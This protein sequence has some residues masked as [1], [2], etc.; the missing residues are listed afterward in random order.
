MAVYELDP[1]TDP[2]WP[3]LIGQHPDSTIFHTR[4]W[5][6]SLKETYGYQPVAY[7][8]SNSRE[9][10]HGIVFCKVRSP[11][12]GNRL[13]SLPFSDHCQPLANASQ[14]GEILQSLQ[15]KSRSQ[16]LKYIEIRPLKG[17][18]FSTAQNLYEA[19]RF[20]VQ[21]IDLRKELSV[22]QR[23]MHDSCIRRK[24]KRAEKEKL[25]Y[26]A[27]SNGDFLQRFRHLFLL[28]RRRHKLPPPPVSWTRNLAH[29]FGKKLT[30]HM[31]LKDGVPAASILTITHKHT[32][33][34]KYGCSD[35]A[36]SNLG[37][38]PFLFWKVIQQAKE[39]NLQEFD[40]GRS[41]YNDFGLITFK[42]HLGASTSDLAYFRNAPSKEP[43][44]TS[45]ISSLID[46]VLSK[47]PDPFL[48]SIGNLLYRHMG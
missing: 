2:R 4:E 31:M 26:Q 22:L 8:T 5:L 21:S 30:I 35:A 47:L 15:S 7:T 33:V 12:T 34:Y 18:V 42:E 24:I 40:L 14:T 32:I 29:A 43:T 38:T 13:V 37:G 44:S 45:R 23:N 10:E 28:T 48:E 6:T 17:D 36:F 11:L 27:G 46:P 19:K 25:D 16:G 39:E 9:L 3:E 20:R 41:D 1:L